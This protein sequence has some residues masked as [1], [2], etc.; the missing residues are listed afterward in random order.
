VGSLI[1]QKSSKKNTVVMIDPHWKLSYL[2]VGVVCGIDH[3]LIDSARMCAG[4]VTWVVVYVERISILPR[5]TYVEE[6][7][8]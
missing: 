6:M 4:V 5:C 1:K 8:D 3:S 7:L 2:R